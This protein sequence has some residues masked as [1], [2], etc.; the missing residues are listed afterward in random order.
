MGRGA[1]GQQLKRKG[2]CHCTSVDGGWN[3][4]FWEVDTYKTWV[5][6]GERHWRSRWAS[7]GIH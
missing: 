7:P 2:V 4:D 5:T 3:L 1:G 6:G